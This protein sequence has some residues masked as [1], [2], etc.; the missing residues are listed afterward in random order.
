MI[1]TLRLNG[2]EVVPDIKISNCE[3]LKKNIYIYIWASLVHMAPMVG[4][5]FGKMGQQLDKCGRNLAAANLP[6][7]GHRALHN[8]I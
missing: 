3:L 1:T 2:Y 8:T 5:Y 6:G 7:Q 4:R